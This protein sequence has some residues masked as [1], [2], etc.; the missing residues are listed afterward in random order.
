MQPQQPQPPKHGKD[1]SGHII[2]VLLMLLLM[3]AGVIVGALQIQKLPPPW[4]PWG[5]SNPDN[6]GL[7]EV[8][9]TPTPKS[10]PG[11]TPSP[12]APQSSICGLWQSETSNKRYNFICQS[13]NFFEIYEVSG[14][15]GLAKVGSG[16]FYGDNIEADYFSITKGRS[17]KLKLK[18][19]ADGR[20]LEGPLQGKDPRESGW[21]IF[22]KISS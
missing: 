13:Q 15:Q 3:L 5:T 16:T 20:K 6:R 21:L 2:V 18:M 11:I 22:H 1:W 14:D 7:V 10:S 17:A 4:W 19:S 8:E 9:P 12:V